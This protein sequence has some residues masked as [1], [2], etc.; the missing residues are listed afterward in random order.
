MDIETRVI[1]HTQ[2]IK[3]DQ[4]SKP[5]I[6]TWKNQKIVRNHSM[7]KT[8]EEILH[9]NENLDVVNVNMIGKPNSGKTEQLRTIAHIGHKISK[10]PYSFKLFDKHALLNFQATLKTLTPTNWFLGFDDLSFLGAQANKKQMEVIKQATTEIRHLP[11]G[12]DVKIIIMKVSHYTLA[13]DK[14]LRQNEFSYFTS[15]GSSE[16]ENMER[17]V[18]S[19]NMAK[20]IFFKKLMVRATSS[21]KYGYQLRPDKPQ[22]V[23]EYKNPFIP[24]LF[25]NEERLRIVDS[26]N[27]KW[28]DEYCDICAS[29]EDNPS[30]DQPVNLDGFIKEKSD[31]YGSSIWK[32]AVKNKMLLKGVNVHH[33]SV[34]SAGRDLDRCVATGKVTLDQIAARLGL[35]KTVTKLKKPIGIEIFKIKPIPEVTDTNTE[36]KEDGQNGQD[37]R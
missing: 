32:L 35:K 30:G 33:P 1:Q 18:G 17:I 36:I 28:L 26:P 6:I 14:Y 11:G 24:M 20:V 29:A 5:S 15:V 23:H 3:R 9:M 16:Y 21:G 34:V 27:R 37:K 7:I 25:W 2:Q 19:N 10:I 4:D 22:L 8:V 13:L 12:Q 31:A